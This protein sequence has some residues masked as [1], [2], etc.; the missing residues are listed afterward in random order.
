M[1][2][3]PR[4]TFARSAFRDAPDPEKRSIKGEQSWYTGPT[5]SGVVITPDISTTIACVYS[6]II[7]LAS[8]VGAMPFN[9]MKRSKNGA[10]TVDWTAPQQDLI[11]H[12]PN[13]EMTGQ[14]WLECQM[15]HCLTRGNTYSR[16]IFDSLSIPERIDLLDPDLVT[17]SRTDAGELYYQVAGE[18][19]PAREILHVKAPGYNGINGKSPIRQ[20]AESFGLTS[21]VEG[22]GQ[23]YFGNGITQSGILTFD[24]DP[25]EDALEE[26][27]KDIHSRHSGITNSHKLMILTNGAKFT[28]TSIPPEDA[29][30]LL[31]RR[32]QL[33]EV[34]RIFR[35]ATSKLQA[36]DKQSYG[37]LEEVNQDYYLS[38]LLPWLTRFEKEWV[39]KLYTAKQRRVWTIEHDQKHLLKG[40]AVDQANVWKIL[41]QLA[42]ASPNE[43]RASYGWA[44]IPG[45]DAYLTQINQANVEQLAKATLADLKG[46]KPTT[47]PAADKPTEDQ[48]RSFL[49]DAAIR[50]IA[51]T[52]TRTVAILP[53]TNQVDQAIDDLVA[54]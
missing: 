12:G 35:V 54:D 50:A 44:P 14:T 33:E 38:S 4:K 16:I 29:Q 51:Q 37:A 32:F 31:T 3:I 42:A 27:R 39:R 22:F 36:F 49:V 46:V 34:C 6:A 9:V 45:G 8:D 5:R 24:D 13:D 19:V 20:C 23:S 40:R 52:T 2:K 17:P 21:S 18:R 48:A 43:I 7:V 10:K 41:A 30:F 28:P 11:F 47:D 25:D 26:I 53:T 15:W 1:A